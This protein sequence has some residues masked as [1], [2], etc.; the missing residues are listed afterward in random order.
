MATQQPIVSTSIEEIEHEVDRC[1]ER[2][3]LAKAIAIS[4][5]APELVAELQQRA[6]RKPEEVEEQ[7]AKAEANAIAALADLRSA[8]S[9]PE[10]RRFSPKALAGRR[11]K[12]PANL[13]GLANS[14]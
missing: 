11:N 8:L 14:C 1:A 5:N 4:E 9:R 2:T 3:R 6:K 10:D 12:A 7:R 13:L